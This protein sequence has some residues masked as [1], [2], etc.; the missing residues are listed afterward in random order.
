MSERLVLVLTASTMLWV[1]TANAGYYADAIH[2]WVPGEGAW[3]ESPGD[4]LGPPHFSV[5]TDA[6]GI[7]RGGTLTLRLSVPFTDGPGMDLTVY[8]YGA[9][10]GG[11]DDSYDVSVS[12]T[13]LPGSFEDVGSALGDAMSFD[14]AGIGYGPYRYVRITDTDTTG[15]Y[16]GADI[17]ATE[18]LTPANFAAR[19]HEWIPGD[20]AWPESPGDPIGPPDLDVTGDAFGIGQGGSIT[21]EMDMPFFD[22]PGDDL[23]VFEYGDSAGGTDDAFQVLVSSDAACFHVLGTSSGDHSLFDLADASLAGP[24]RYVKIVDL[25]TTFDGADIDAVQAFTPE[26]ATLSLLGLGGFALL[27]RRRRA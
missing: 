19:I 14:L 25:N 13:G 10:T 1:G 23:K 24:F 21:L 22:G 2:E 27:R 6:Y 9:S 18:V 7:G 11:T 3:A 5:S 26:P 4:P 20:G 17:D 15:Q 16:D 12:S 8:E